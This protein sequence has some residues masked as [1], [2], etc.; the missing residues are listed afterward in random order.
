MR[1]NLPINIKCR[2][3]GGHV[4][5]SMSIGRQRQHI[6][7]TIEPSYLISVTLR[8]STEVIFSSAPCGGFTIHFQWD[9]VSDS[10]EVYTETSIRSGNY[11]FCWTSH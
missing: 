7:I 3:I 8:P 4:I 9:K 2:R 1:V 5:R 10:I 6:N 11:Y